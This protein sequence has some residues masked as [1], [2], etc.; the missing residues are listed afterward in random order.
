MVTPQSPRLMVFVNLLSAAECDALVAD[1]KGRIALSTV[2]DPATGE[3]IPHQERTSQGTY[4]A[5]GATPLVATIEERIHALLG[6][7]LKRQEAMQMLRYPVGGEYRPHLDYFDPADPGSAAPMR[8][9]GQRVAKLVVYLNDVES[10]GATD[11][12]S[13]GLTIAPVKGNAVYFE[14]V[15]GSGL[16]DPRTLHAG[17]PITQGE[18]WI[19]TK[20]FRERDLF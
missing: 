16:P 12:P 8:Q 15:D 1:T 11:F 9:G 3:F 17:M 14:N 18:K 4:F 2:V 10:G 13:L 7:P 20:W 5:H 6:Y 19:S